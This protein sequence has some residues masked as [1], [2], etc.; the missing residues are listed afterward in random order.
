LTLTGVW[1]AT[2]CRTQEDD[3]FEQKEKGFAARQFSMLHRSDDN[4]SAQNHASQQ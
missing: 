1:D 3:S 4:H 2:T